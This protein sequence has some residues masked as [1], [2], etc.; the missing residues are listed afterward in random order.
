MAFGPV[1]IGG[2][3]SASTLE[4]IYDGIQAVQK[5]SAE[6]IQ[7][8]R[9]ET[10]EAMA[11]HTSASNPHGVTAEDIGA[12]PAER[13][14]NGKA[15][16]TDLTLSAEDVSA[17]P[18]SRKVNGKA[19]STDITLSATDVGAAAASHSHSLSSLGAAAASHSHS[20]ESLSGKVFSAGKTA[21]SN[22][23]LLWIDTTANTGGLKYYNGSAWVHVPVAYT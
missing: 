3:A 5:E 9:R 12:V 23:G 13:K 16:N 20:F 19:L 4:G 17:V 2:G 15:L 7:E 11:A 14:I 18:T 6:A 21:P 10:A 8:V 1:N 22:K